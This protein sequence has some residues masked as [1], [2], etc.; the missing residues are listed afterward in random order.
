MM[1]G[2]QAAVTDHEVEATCWGWQNSKIEGVWLSGNF[3]IPSPV[4]FYVGDS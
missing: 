4:V 1:A 2:T 3:G